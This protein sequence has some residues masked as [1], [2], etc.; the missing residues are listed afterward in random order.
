MQKLQDAL[1]SKDAPLALCTWRMEQREKRPLR[2][3]V[4]DV[5]EVCLEVRSGPAPGPLRKCHVVD[6]KLATSEDT[7]KQSSY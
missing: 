7:S 4:R 6:Q 3:Q 1:A 2:E 5:V